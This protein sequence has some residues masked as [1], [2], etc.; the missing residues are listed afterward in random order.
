MA[1]NKFLGMF[2][3]EEVKSGG[4]EDIDMSQYTNP[5]ATAQFKV[6]SSNNLSVEAIYNQA[7]PNLSDMEK[8]IFKIE[9]I[10]KVLPANLPNEAKKQSVLG[11]MAV[12]G[13]KLEDVIY[14]T[15]MRES[16]LVGVLEAFTADTKSVI[17]TCETSIAE[18]EAAINNLKEKMT[19]MNKIQEDQES[20]VENE[21]LKIKAIKD[22]IL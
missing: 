11:M 14:D 12:T 21:L 1:K 13:L 18:H 8:S 16:E 20:I 3:E 10:R 6:D 22:F 9:E 2:F 15:D 17:L 19:L 4:V 7:E 5:V